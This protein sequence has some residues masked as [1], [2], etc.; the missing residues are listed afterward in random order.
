MGKY[1][2]KK[3]GNPR[4]KLRDFLYVVIWTLDYFTTLR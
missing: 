2:K 1:T 3:R 4:Q